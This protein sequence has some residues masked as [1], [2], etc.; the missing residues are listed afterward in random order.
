MAKLLRLTVDLEITDA[1]HHVD[2][3]AESASKH[4]LKRLQEIY[5]EKKQVIPL[6]VSAEV[7]K[8]IKVKNGEVV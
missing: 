6:Q 2:Q 3:V 5:E 8:V 7:I 4:V 1:I